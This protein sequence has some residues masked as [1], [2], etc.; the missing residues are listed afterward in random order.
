M[1]GLAEELLREI[2]HAARLLAQSPSFTA[3]AV[4]SLAIGIGATTAVFSVADGTLLHPLPYANSDQLM[5][6]H[7]TSPAAAKDSVSYPNFLDWRAR[8]RAFEVLAAWHL[9]MF[10]LAGDQ[11][12]ERVIGG[13]VS[14]SYFSA[15][16]VTALVGRTFAAEEDQPGGPRVVLIG[17]SLWRRRFDADPK[18]V[19]APITLDDE[20]YTVIGVIPSHVGVGVI[21]RLY[22]DVFVPL[23]QNDDPVFWS[24]HAHTISVIG[25]LRPGMGRIQAQAE[26][27][28][29][30]A[31][32]AVAFPDA[33][34]GQGVSVVL[35]AD[36]LIGDVR[37]TI[38]LLLSAVAFVWLI[39]CT[40]VTNLMLA[41]NARRTE[42]FATRLAVGASRWRLIRQAL[43]ESTCLAGT[44]AVAGLVFAA[45]ATHAAL[46][47]LPSALPD[48]V[49]VE[50]NGRVLLVAAVASLVSG[51]ICGIVPAI[52]ATRLDVSQGLRHSQRTLAG[53]TNRSQRVFLVAQLAMT[54]TLM[55]GTGLLT[56]SLVQL[57]SVDP[58][59]DPTNVVTFMSGL[60]R[61]R[62]RQPEQVRAAIGLIT[63]RLT[64]VPL[65]Q[66]ASGVVG[67]LPY[68]GNNNAV[69]FWRADSPEP[70]GSDAPLALFSAVGSEYFRAMQIP[71]RM[72]RG[73]AGH[74]S[75]ES[76]RVAIIDTAFAETVFSGEDPL[77]QRLRIDPVD[78]PVEVVG[79]V[80]AV[81][82]WG[83]DGRTGGNGARVHIYVPMAQLPD[84]LTPLAA[85]AFS[86][87]VRTPAA[88]TEM[89]DTLRK[90]LL[91]FNDGQTLIR[92][93]GMEDGV[94]RSLAD[95]RFTLALLGTFAVLGLA[96]S[97]VG[98]YG[99]AS[100]LATLRTREIG[101][102]LALGA[103]RRDIG[104]IL[105]APMG[106]VVLMG[107]AA[108]L[109]ASMGVTHLIAS[110]LFG[111]SSTDPLTLGA[112]AGLLTLI[113]SIALLLPLRRAWRVNP[114]VALRPE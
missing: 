66:A 56:R 25:R 44:G 64:A 46:A 84:S 28:T 94:A 14:S 41:R 109:L 31:A 4:L 59:F 74:D 110:L 18:V 58:G 114:V 53:H 86:V 51:L 19:G 23:G 89:L 50:I 20:P 91:E 5:A 79:V 104:V 92:G 52:R 68:T 16:R 55:T 33:N 7:G 27:T 97:I 32:L 107:I 54:V 71:I 93:M 2:R 36:D 26:M 103:Q 13:R 10:T 106:T 82:H 39:G 67:A 57:W 22:N 8:S 9:E 111:V 37:P 6:V 81:K 21:P 90:A 85:T 60:P 101:V 35:L 98:V 65:V 83:L 105:L 99:V 43:V 80:G 40:N 24:R 108:G 78:E 11:V 34:S 73:F 95:R 72:G 45:W 1:N 30:A 88:S 47:V 17:E 61:E 62:A 3:A 96:L 113:A 87:V 29:I 70:T 102:R 42:E 112:V 12:G 48:V 69:D 76:P 15:L 100:Y 75:S 63:E 38:L 49:T 77:G